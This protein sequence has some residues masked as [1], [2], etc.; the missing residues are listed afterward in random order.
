MNKPIEEVIDIDECNTI[1]TIGADI[2]GG[3]LPKNCN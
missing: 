3:C 2:V 1:S